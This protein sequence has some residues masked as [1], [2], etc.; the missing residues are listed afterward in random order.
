MSWRIVF[1]HVGRNAQ[2]IA[3]ERDDTLFFPR[4]LH[5]TVTR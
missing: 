1:R 2:N 4:Q 3:G 5:V